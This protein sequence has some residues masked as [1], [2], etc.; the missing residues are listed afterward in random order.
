[1]GVKPKLFYLFTTNGC[2]GEYDSPKWNETIETRN[3]FSQMVQEEGPFNLMRGIVD[4]SNIFSEFVTVIDSM[5]SPGILKV[6][7]RTVIKVIPH[8]KYIL[9][10]ISPGD[11]I[12]ARG[13]F[14]QWY[15]TLKL[16]S[17]KKSNWIL[18]Y[19]ANTNR[20]PWTFWDIVL[21]DL[22]A[23][24][25]IIRD[26]KGPRLHFPYSKPVREDLFYPENMD[27]EFDLMLGAS[28]IHGKKGQY[29]ALRAV[30]EYYNLTGKKLRCIMPGRAM[31][32]MTNNY[33]REII[34]KKDVDMIAPGM[35]NRHQLRDYMNKSKLFIHI[36]SG[37]Q[38][39]R[40]VLEAMRCGVP[41]LISN[42]KAWSP[43][44]SVRQRICT[45]TKDKMDSARVAR[46]M[47]GAYIQNT[48][49]QEVSDYYMANNGI[50]EVCKPKL[51]KVF[52]FC[53]GNLP[54]R[55]TAITYFTSIY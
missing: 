27:K 3:H 34:A 38:N 19:R 12:Y 51:E 54:N 28:H 31:K 14:K 43:F 40:G 52:K 49:R 1:M 22:I 16:I 5:R 25:Q 50:K 10:D 53:I 35:V 20:G 55:S 36:G 9:K 6:D 44:V 15:N 37:G 42:P 23:T 2:C 21:D 18:F 13:G 48:S 33:I 26:G 32:D 45:V 46:D 30:I 47:H 7:E 24:P 17:N 11:V 4:T 29:L 8:L 41:I 39:D